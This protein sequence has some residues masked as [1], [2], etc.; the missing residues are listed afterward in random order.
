[1]S[2][3]L[4]PPK[5]GAIA[6]DGRDDLVDVVGGQH[7]R[8]RRQA[9]ELAE[10]A[11]LALHHRQGR[12]RAD[13]AEAQDGAAVG[14]DGDHPRRPGE[15][16]GERGLGRDGAGDTGDAGRVGEGEVGDRVDRPG[17]RHRELAALVHCE[18]GIV[19]EPVGPCRGPRNP[20]CRPWSPERNRLGWLRC[21]P[22]RSE[23]SPFPTATCSTW[24]RTAIPGAGSPSGTAPTCSSGAVGHPLHA[25]P[26]EPQRLGPRRPARR[27]LRQRSAR[28]GEVRLLPGRPAARRRRRPAGRLPHVRRARRRRPR[29]RAA[30]G[31]VP[32]RGAG[33]RLPVAGRRHVGDL[34]G[35]HQ[36]RPGARVHG[37]APR[38]RAGPAL[39]GRRRA[40]ALRARPRRAP[41]LA[42]ARGRACCRR[43]SSAPPGTRSYAG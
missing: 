17:R 30:A 38:P 19:G 8:H 6:V 12:G 33:A 25:G 39:A 29:L 36:L 11:G 27:P 26:G 4:M 23:S 13:V 3:R 18:R 7:D 24:C 22:W 28:A 41:G 15:A 43:R 10:Q 2:S 37:L 20:G 5:E 1:M 14:D 42:E 35:V 40:G 21:V 9:T 32:R 16:A 34:S 31:R